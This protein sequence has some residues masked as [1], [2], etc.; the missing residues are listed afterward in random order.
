MRTTV[1]DMFDLS[2]RVAVIT[3]GAGLLGRKHAEAIAELGGIPVIVDIDQARC[4][5][6]AQA[7]AALG[8]DGGGSCRGY[9]ADITS[10]A[11]VRSLEER[12]MNEFGRIDI[13][14]NNAANNPAVGAAGLEGVHGSRLEAFDLAHWNQDI[15]VGLTGA[16]LCARTFGARMAEQGGGVILNIASDL[17]LISPDQ[18]LYRKPGLEEHAQ[19]VKPVTYS[20]VKSGL[21]GLTRYLATYWAGQ[22][23][24]CNALSPGG[25]YVDQDDGFVQRLSQLIPMGRMAGA[26]EYKAAVAFLVSD[27]S[28]YMT[29][30][31][32]VADGGRTV[33]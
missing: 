31:N 29:G 10:D 22:G 27:A 26:D 30:A 25:V 11:Q 33:W 18:R 9:Q 8:G 4:D 20:V 15:A 21:I 7:I 5:R 24:R 28:S 12:L 1:R 17:A 13:L 16:F 3:G 19:P 23:V 2:G 32:L 14:I 6:A